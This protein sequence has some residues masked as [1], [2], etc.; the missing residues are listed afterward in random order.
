MLLLLLDL[1][2]K[3]YVW[4]DIGDLKIV[5]F[6]YVASE[7]IFKVSLLAL[8]KTHYH[9]KNFPKRDEF[10]LGRNNKI[11]DSLINK[12]SKLGFSPFHIK[13]ILI[14]KI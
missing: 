7:G 8:K 1:K 4:E 13:L 11:F 14:K 3:K 9:K 6:F 5:V 12:P 2:F 10:C